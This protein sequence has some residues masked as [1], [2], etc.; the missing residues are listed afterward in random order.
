MTSSIVL[1]RQKVKSKGKKDLTSSSIKPEELKMNIIKPAAFDAGWSTS[2]S[3]FSLSDKGNNFFL[4][5]CRFI[6]R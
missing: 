5:S 2:L 6:A 1:R 3:N 4:I